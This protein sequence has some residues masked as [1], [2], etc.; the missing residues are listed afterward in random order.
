MLG[1]IAGALIGRSIDQRD[2]RGGLKGALMG[3]ATAGA[4]RRM[5]PLGLAIGGGIMAKRYMDK[6]KA[7]RTVR[8]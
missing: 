8:Y 6:R 2:G 7:A 1:K 3:A 4:L 5:G